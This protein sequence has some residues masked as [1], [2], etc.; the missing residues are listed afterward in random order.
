LVP[1]S[2]SA[3]IAQELKSLKEEGFTVAPPG[4]LGIVNGWA[5]N[6]KLPPYD[7]VKVPGIPGWHQ[8]PGNHRYGL[9][10]GLAPARVN[11]DPSSFCVPVLVE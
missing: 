5:A 3:R 6:T 9:Y 11:V 7:D 1:F 2:C 4:Y 8:S 10:A